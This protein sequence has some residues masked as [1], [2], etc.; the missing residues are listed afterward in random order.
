MLIAIIANCIFVAIDEAARSDDNKDNA[1]WL[2]VET[3]FCLIFMGEFVI[4]FL[5]VKFDYFRN[6]VN[7]FDFSLVIL[8]VVG[9]V[10]GILSRQG[11][12]E[13]VHGTEAR[14]IKIARV[15]RVL[16]LLRV[17]RLFNARLNNNK[18]VSPTVANHVKR[19]VT[20]KCF[21]QA[22]LEAQLQ[23]IKYFGGNAAIDSEDEAEMARCILQSQ[24]FVYKALEM[25]VK[26]EQCMNQELLQEVSW[27][28]KT[29]H[30]SEKLLGFVMS[31]HADGAISSTEAQ[32]ILHPLHHSIE[33]TL[34][35]LRDLDEGIIEAG[36]SQAELDSRAN[37]TR[38]HR[39][40]LQIHKASQHLASEL[41]LLQSDLN[42]V[43]AESGTWAQAS[44]TRTLDSSIPADDPASKLDYSITPVESM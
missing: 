34:A 1:A 38:G 29:K 36:P 32:A 24:C 21:C 28:V 14:L 18:N 27:L 9:V 17:F 23:L 6:G 16:R 40:S 44:S 35:R 8:G 4:K 15:F 11:D 37:S 25:A 2:A 13:Q 31:A 5:D 7:L 19:V 22:H 41:N 33:D 3:F 39:P 42:C 12:G 10:T 43:E 20:L 26:E 30:V